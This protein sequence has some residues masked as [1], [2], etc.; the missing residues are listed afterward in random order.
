MR[1]GR[2]EKI[3]GFLSPL[4]RQDVKNFLVGKRSYSQFFFP[5]LILL[6]VSHTC[7]SIG[8]FVKVCLD[9]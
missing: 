2:G 1:S 6:A 5:S 3:N 8:N 7:Y 4:E 9:W